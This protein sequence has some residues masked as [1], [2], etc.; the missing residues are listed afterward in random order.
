[1]RQ[2]IILLVIVVLLAGLAA[3]LALVD[4]QALSSLAAPTAAASGTISPSPTAQASAT[5]AVTP[6]PTSI[7]AAEG[8]AGRNVKYLDEVVFPFAWAVLKLLAVVISAFLVVYLLNIV[9]QN[10]FFPSPQLVFENVINSTGDPSLDNLAAGLSSLAGGWIVKELNEGREIARNISRRVLEDPIGRDPDVIRISNA[11]DNRAAE[12]I[13]AASE[14]APE[15]IKPVLGLLAGLFPQRGFRMKSDLLFLPGAVVERSV[16]YE[17]QDLGK[18]LSPIHGEISASRA[19]TA[20]QSAAS[21]KLTPLLKLCRLLME[22]G[23]PEGAAE[24]LYAHLSILP[25][26][27]EAGALLQECLDWVSP[28]EGPGSGEAAAEKLCQAAGIYYE[29]GDLPEAKKY[30]QTALERSP[31]DSKARAMI[32]NLTRQLER[33][34]ES[35]SD[36]LK[37]AGLYQRLGL[38]DD[39]RKFAAQA[40]AENPDDIRAQELLKKNFDQQEGAVKTYRRLLSLAIRIMVTEMMGQELLHAN[41]SKNGA[42]RAR[43]HLLIGTLYESSLRG[44]GERVFHDLAR[45]QFLQAAELWPA[46]GRPYY[47]L[48]QVLSFANRRGLLTDIPHDRKKIEEALR[49]FDLAVELEKKQ[50]DQIFMTRSLLGEANMLIRTGR[51]DDLR[52]AQANIA[53][54]IRPGRRRLA[55]QLY[56]P[57]LY[58]LACWFGLAFQRLSKSPE[59]TDQ[60]MACRCYALARWFLPLFLLRDQYREFWEQAERD[61]DLREVIGGFSGLKDEI[62]KHPDV[63]RNIEKPGTAAELH[64]LAHRLVLKANWSLFKSR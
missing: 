62:R 24:L 29:H 56:T 48:A 58:T 11:Y 14:A 26:E 41:R 60:R 22:A 6:T 35:I 46:S 32:L 19:S 38:P 10:L 2:R 27:W 44:S 39:A 57:D 5:P 45:K 49:Y 40:L 7:A 34:G 9:I 47:Y 64:T 21:W 20:A 59:K 1:M 23:Y 36:N 25:D 50:S 15:E 12:L 54:I 53:H 18:K 17:L 8:I 4:L 13:K 3:F 51:I 30:L 43:I 33:A 63:Y 61:P 52:R 55:F 28:G 37:L 42:Y 31:N 16:A